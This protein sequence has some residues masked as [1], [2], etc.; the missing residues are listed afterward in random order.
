MNIK[1]D[2]NSE[3]LKCSNCNLFTNIIKTKILYSKICLH[4]ICETCFRR[5]ITQENP[6]YKCNFCQ[7]PHDHKSYSDKTKE[8]LYFDFD[9]R[10]RQKLMQV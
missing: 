7:K 5:V 6:I 8:E 10:T 4:R 1:N 2:E 3:L 9:Y